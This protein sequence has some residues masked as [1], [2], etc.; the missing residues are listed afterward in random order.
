MQRGRCGCIVMRRAA[1]V[2]KSYS[3]HIVCP[4]FALT[5]DSLNSIVHPFRRVFV[6]LQKALYQPAH[7][8]SCALFLLPVNRPVLSEHI[9]QFLRN[10]YQ[11]I[12]L[13]EVFDCL[14]LRECVIKGKLVCCQSEFFSFG[15]SGSNVFC[16]LE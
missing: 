5:H 14:R 13:I 16:K 11:F 3:H 9:C 8:S 7:S 4:H 10:R 1:G 6:F 15:S 2:R 12:V